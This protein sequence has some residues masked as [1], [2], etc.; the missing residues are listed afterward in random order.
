MEEKIV[1]Q[2]FDRILSGFEKLSEVSI[3]ISDCSEICRNYQSFG[4]EGYRLGDYGGASYLNRYLGCTV[5]R[6]PMLMYKKKYL[7]P[8]VFRSAP[9]SWN[10]FNESTRFTGFFY[11]LE[12][13]LSFQPEKAIIDYHKLGNPSNESDRAIIDSAYIVFRLSEIVDGAGFPISQM[14]CVEEFS[15]WNRGYRLIDNGQIGRHSRAF[16]IEN[17][18][19]V[20]ELQMI[21]K[22]VKLKYPQTIL[23]I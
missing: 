12:W 4:V 7:I 23:F 11:L 6:A 3:S 16:D 5:D 10:L 1:L 9:E 20:S 18:K 21:L 8:M 13:L 22:I 19:N 17:E 15:L 2:P 14:T